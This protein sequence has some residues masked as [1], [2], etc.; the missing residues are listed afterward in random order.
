MINGF[1]SIVNR[2][3]ASTP[4]YPV[5]PN[6]MTA[7]TDSL[8]TKH[9]KVLHAYD[10]QHDD[11]LTIRPGKHIEFIL[12]F[13]F[14]SGGFLGDVIVLIERRSDQWCKGNLN[15]RIGLF[16]GNFVQEI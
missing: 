7:S 1:L 2:S 13:F 15:G 9:M 8:R 16:P 10:A 14:I 6:A 4:P 5:L 12:T 3:A 11:E